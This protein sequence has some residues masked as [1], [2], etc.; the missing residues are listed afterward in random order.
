[1]ILS[2]EQTFAANAPVRI[3]TAFR[4]FRLIS[5]PAAVTIEFGRGG[6]L[7]EK[8]ESI[9]AGVWFR[10]RP[11]SPDYAI[12]KITNP[13]LQ[14]VKWV[15]AD[16]DAGYDRAFGSVSISGPLLGD[17]ADAV[18]GMGAGTLVGGIARNQ[19]YNGATWDRLR[20][21]NE[22]GG[23]GS[24]RVTQFS[25]AVVVNGQAYLAGTAVAAAG[26]LIAA[27]QLFNPGGSGK[28][29]YVDAV[30]G[31]NITAADRIE[32]RQ[33]SAA[34][35]TLISTGLYN[36]NVGGAAGVAQLRAGT[37]AGAGLVMRA[38]AKPV[39][40][41]YIA[42]FVPPIRVPETFGVHVQAVTVNTGLAASFDYREKAT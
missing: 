33:H 13:G 14:A 7:E 19:A 27:V 18:V 20:A 32:I 3:R 17:D 9:D 28:T 6:R 15:L 10:A 12:L 8:I 4:F 22:G 25:D 36:R 37:G 38:S 26:G 29:L 11:G 24:L 34:V 42:R 23:A 41:P 2:Y 5:A 31:V 16:D 40:E 35:L 21:D 1:M 30:E 39:N